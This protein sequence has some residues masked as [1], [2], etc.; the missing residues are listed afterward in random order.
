M[1]NP[2]TYIGGINISGS[3]PVML[4]P[5]IYYMQGGG[6]SVSGPANVTGSNVL[7]VNA[8]G[9]TSAAIRISGQA[10]V[11][12]SALTSGLDQGVVILQDPASA[13]PVTFS[14]QSA[15][16]SLTGVVYVPDA[17]VQIS[18]NA[19]VTINAS[20]KGQG[21]LTLPPI[22][23]ALIAFD[24]H[25]GTNGV[26]TINPDDPPAAPSSAAAASVV[27]GALADD[28]SM[29]Q[30]SLVLTGGQ[31]AAGTSP[32][33]APIAPA[34]Q[35]AA[36]QAARGPSYLLNTGSTAVA[37]SGGASEQADYWLATGLDALAAVPALRVV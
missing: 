22:L 23:G 25:V 34:G 32:S 29:R 31:P 12:L 37:L 20:Q 7:I 14:G 19:Q 10:H 36:V 1:L 3:G 17:L 26:L 18:G 13:N 27:G 35:S 8:P 30:V 16:I 11:T 24:L 15:V 28:S 2:G 33:P 6:F 5:G 9:A 21:T 4:T